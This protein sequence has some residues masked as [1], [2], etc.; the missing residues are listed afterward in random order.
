MLRRVVTLLF[1][2]LRYGSRSF[3]FIFALVMPLFLSLVLGLVFGTLFSQQPRLGI[4]DAGASRL[5]DALLA[6]DFMSVTRFAS[7]DAL[8]QALASGGVEVGLVLPADFDARLT[9]NAR[10]DLTLYIWGQTLIRSRAIIS[11]AISERILD[12]TGRE[13]PIDIEVVPLGD[14][15]AV[16]WQQ[17]LLPLIVLMAIFFGG[18]LVPATSMIEERQQRTLT[19]L[20]TTPMSLVEVFLAKGLLGVLLAIF[21]GFAILTLNGGWGPNPLLLL[22]VLAIGGVLAA[23]YG[24]F[25]G[26][27]VKDIQTLFAINKSMG[28]I[29]YAPALIALFPETIPQW[30]AR[31]FPTY[32]ILQPVLDISQRGAG[33]AEILPDLTILLI[34]TGA[35]IAAI[36]LTAER[37]QVR[38]A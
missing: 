32:Y 25:L 35:L 19:A 13:T 26:S 17:R 6:V 29:L 37:L 27:R 22:F 5:T 11:A 38:T 28:I 36:A 1:K 30:I 14:R 12:L 23:A 10:T 8:Q 4:Y 16:S 20:T 15:A 34:L 2:D 18:M 31:L 21:T 7:Q 3:I 33:L 24:I 9:A